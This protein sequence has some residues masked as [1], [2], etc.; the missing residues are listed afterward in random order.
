MRVVRHANR[1]IREHQAPSEFPW[2]ARVPFAAYVCWNLA[3]LASGRIPPSALRELFG[4]PCPTTGCT[5]SLAAILHGNLIAS[6][7]WNLFT[8]PILILLAISMQLLFLAAV[9]KKELVLPKWMGT[10]WLC[11][12]VMAWISKFVL[13]SAYW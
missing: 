1:M 8:I 13:G 4:I 7:R 11:V 6:L 9:R 5:R 3:W 10:A 2:W 12:L